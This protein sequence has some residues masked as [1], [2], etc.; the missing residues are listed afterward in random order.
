MGSSGNFHKNLR[1]RHAKEYAEHREVESA[2]SNVETNVSIEYEGSSYDDKVNQS[3]VLNLI[4][5]CNLPPSMVEHF[6]FSEIY[7]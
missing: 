1:R 6:F 5:Q 2:A 3:M 4:V 7:E